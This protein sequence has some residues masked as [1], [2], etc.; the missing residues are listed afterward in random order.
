MAQ[1]AAR[2]GDKT[3]GH[4]AF[5][6]TTISEGASKTL[7]E[8]QAAA[9][10]GDAAIPHTETKKPYSTHKPVLSEG[11]SK[12]LIEGQAASRVGDGFACGD[13]VASGSAKVIIGG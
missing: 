2:V 7:I 8:G 12:V 13:T 5:P 1:P 6:S 3:M 9:R 4:D 10:V 11:S